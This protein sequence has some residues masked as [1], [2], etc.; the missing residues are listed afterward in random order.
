MNNLSKIQLEILE[1]LDREDHP[2]KIAFILDI[3]VCDIYDLLEMLEGSENRN[4]FETIS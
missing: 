3:P 1:M 4:L 2:C